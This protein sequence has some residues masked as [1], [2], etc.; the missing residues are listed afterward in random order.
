MLRC[1]FVRRV[2][3]EILTAPAIPATEVETL[4]APLLKKDGGAMETWACFWP[5]ATWKSPAIVLMMDWKKSPRAWSARCRHNTHGSDHMA[6]SQQVW[7]ALQRHDVRA[8]GMRGT[9]WQHGGWC[10]TSTCLMAV[11]AWLLDTL[12][13]GV[14]LLISHSC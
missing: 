11:L 1:R 6:A 10:V 8:A 13:L 9:T 7:K 12:E 3:P 2:L 14:I 4:A 5:V